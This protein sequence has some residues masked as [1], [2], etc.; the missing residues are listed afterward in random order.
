ME[1]TEYEPGTFHP[2]PNSEWQCETTDDGRILELEDLYNLPEGVVPAFKSA[3]TL[4]TIPGAT[5]T[6]KGI[7]M[8]KGA[9]ASIKS[10]KASKGTKTSK[11]ARVQNIESSGLQDNFFSTTSG[12]QDED[13]FFNFGGRRLAQTVDV[14]RT[15]LVVRVIASDGSSTATP[16]QLSDSVF[17]TDGDPVNLK[18]QYDACSYGKLNFIPAPDRTATGGGVDI[19]NGATE[20]SIATSVSQGDIVM[21]N[22]ISSQLAANFGITGNFGENQDLADYLMYCLPVGTMNGIAYA[23]VDSWMSVYSDLWCTYLR[24][25]LRLFRVGLIC[26]LWII[27]L[28]LFYSLAA[29]TTRAVLSF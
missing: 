15:V 2:G 28:T 13:N 21:R 3:D 8:P 10:T 23:F 29:L 5:T 17:G 9:K 11:G 4:L 1:L 16:A 19:V 14:T 18:S 12:T 27:Y 26:L 24:C 7:K 22:A 6:S 20:V 25:E